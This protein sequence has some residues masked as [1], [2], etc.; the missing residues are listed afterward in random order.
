MIS[1]PRLQ[2]RKLP[3]TE[4]EISETLR[5]RLIFSI[6]SIQN[7]AHE[8]SSDADA[9]PAQQNCTRDAPPGF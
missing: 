9:Q 4:T 8:V 7:E 3:E 2:D 6:V 5:F 1:N